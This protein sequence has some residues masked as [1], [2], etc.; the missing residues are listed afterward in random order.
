MREKKG[1]DRERI[2]FF[3][4]HLSR[5]FFFWAPAD[6]L[7]RLAYGLQPRYL[8]MQLASNQVQRHAERVAMIALLFCIFV[9]HDVR[10]TKAIFGIA[11]ACMHSVLSMRIDAWHSFSR[12][13]RREEATQALKKLGTREVSSLVLLKF[14]KGIGIGTGCIRLPYSLLAGEALY[15]SR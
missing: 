12:K 7:G 5:Y 8:L 1:R 11:Q 14:E 4:L 9:L 13:G 10:W 3:S 15:S 6:L 2:Q